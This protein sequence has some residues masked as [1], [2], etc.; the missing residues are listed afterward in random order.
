MLLL[1]QLPLLLLSPAM[2]ISSLPPGKGELGERIIISS[3]MTIDAI[4][5]KY[6]RFVF[7]AGI[8]TP[9]PHHCLLVKELGCPVLIAS[10]DG[11][12][13]IKLLSGLARQTPSL[14]GNGEA[15]GH[16]LSFLKKTSQVKAG[17]SNFEGNGA[18]S[19]NYRRFLQAEGRRK[20]G[21]G[22]AMSPSKRYPVVY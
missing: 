9:H 2:A 8:L 11:A 4:F 20:R 1:I 3:Y 16:R 7:L 22:M 21:E 14:R 5:L 19:R 10:G 6:Y 15:S 12:S 17:W 13:E 18:P